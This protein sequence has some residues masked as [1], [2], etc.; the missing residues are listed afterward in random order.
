MK[1]DLQRVRSYTELAA[2]E[3]P[4]R[5]PELEWNKILALAYMRDKGI[6]IDI[7][8]M[9]DAAGFR[10]YKKSSG[11]P[12]EWHHLKDHKELIAELERIM[13]ENP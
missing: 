11:I 9:Q 10:V 3:R 8:P 12:M 6:G 1:E 5:C 4:E 2:Q 7:V 13:E